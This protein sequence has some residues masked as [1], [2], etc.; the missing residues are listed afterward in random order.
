MGW[1]RRKPAVRA[2]RERPAVYCVVESEKSMVVVV[3]NPIQSIQ[4]KKKEDEEKEVSRCCVVWC[5]GDGA[6]LREGVGTA[7]ACGSE[8]CLL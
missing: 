4:V 2:R 5:V 6:A 1:K 8:S 7:G 3:I